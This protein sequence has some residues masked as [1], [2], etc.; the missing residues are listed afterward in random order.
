MGFELTGV[1][2]VAWGCIRVEIVENSPQYAKFSGII[3][4][5]RP[6]DAGRRTSDGPETRPVNL[7]NNVGSS[8]DGLLEWFQFDSRAVISNEFDVTRV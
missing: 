4:D 1:G 8:K 6:L 7:D 5:S 3:D 2:E